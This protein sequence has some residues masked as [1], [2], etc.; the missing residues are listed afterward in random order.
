MLYFVFSPVRFA[1]AV[2][3]QEQRWLWTYPDTSG[4]YWRLSSL[5][6]QEGVVSMHAAKAVRSATRLGDA[7]SVE[8]VARSACAMQWLHVKVR[9]RH[10]HVF[11][12]AVYHLPSLSPVY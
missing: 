7:C 4:G 11:T 3:N 9:T 1:Q 5:I 6:Q 12:Q 10:M 2:L 8:S